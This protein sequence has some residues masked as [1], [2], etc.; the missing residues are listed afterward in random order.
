ME[1]NE[2][3]AQHR[4]WTQILGSAI[5]LAVVQFAFADYELGPKPHATKKLCPENSCL[6]T[7]LVVSILWTIGV[8]LL[9]HGLYGLRGAIAGFVLNAIFTVWIYYSYYRLLQTR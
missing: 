7:Y 3:L 5:V 9:L 6:H 2:P 8:I 4:K 1:M